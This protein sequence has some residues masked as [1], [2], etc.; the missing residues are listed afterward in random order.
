MYRNKIG[1]V[2]YGIHGRREIFLDWFIKR[3]FDKH[4]HVAF[5]LLR[6]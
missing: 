4:T 3:K 6:A 1:G 2:S 5:D